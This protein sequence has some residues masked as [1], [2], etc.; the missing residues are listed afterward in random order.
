MNI[1]NTDFK[2]PQLDLS[3]FELVENKQD[4]DFLDCSWK[5][6]FES[7][8]PG[9]AGNWLF[10]SYKFRAS[11]IDLSIHI[12][13]NRNIYFFLSDLPVS[14]STFMD[15]INSYITNKIVQTI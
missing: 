5:Y 15:I 14:F 8:F 10:R 9:C 7:F 11:D 1:A 13:Q 2:Y 12:R 3:L 4:F 6:E